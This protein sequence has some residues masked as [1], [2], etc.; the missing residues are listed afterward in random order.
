MLT[1][2]PATH[3]PGSSTLALKC[4]S[5]LRDPF[6]S[7]SAQLDRAI[8]YI[9]DQVLFHPVQDGQHEPPVGG[10]GFVGDCGDGAHGGHGGGR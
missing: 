10:G 5:S 7:S 1:T 4:P 2:T 3:R 8:L 9:R 6:H